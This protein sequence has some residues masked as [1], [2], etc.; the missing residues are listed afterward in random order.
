[1]EFVEWCCS[2]N[3]NKSKNF[4][5]NSNAFEVIHEEFVNDAGRNDDVINEVREERRLEGHG[6][7]QSSGADEYAALKKLIPIKYHLFLK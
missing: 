1:M 3:N 2:S 4:T 5:S 7:T 6:I